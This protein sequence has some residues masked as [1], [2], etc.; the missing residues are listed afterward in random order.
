MRAPAIAVLL[1][2]P[3]AALWLAG[4][5]LLGHALYAAGFPA[6]SA[7][8]FDDPAW[9]GAALHAAGRWREAA[10]AFARDPKQAYNRAG[11]LARAGAYAQAVEAYDTAIDAAPDDADA[12]FNR[13]IVAQLAAGAI[14]EG[15]DTKGVDANSRA[16]ADRH[17]HAIPP[18]EG[19]TG[20]SGDGFAGTQEGESAQSAKGGSKVARAS[21]GKDKPSG[22]G[23]GE[24]SGSAGN[25]DGE[26][27]SGAL[28]ADVA[29]IL[30]K[31]NRK[32]Q[33][34]QYAQSVMP[35]AEWLTTRPDD[36]G[37]YLKLRILAEQAARKARPAAVTDP[38]DGE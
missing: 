19:Q 29:R 3:A 17:G 31:T 4:L 33:R 10:E 8:F 12:K 37:K 24:A 34:E 5:P 1:L 13:E 16:I 38:E 32:I 6:A 26:G 9:Q 30:R 23:G 15:P 7:R 28:L 35:T 22:E 25:S 27:Q 18:A 14:A 11:A 20:G 36:P 2:V 21:K